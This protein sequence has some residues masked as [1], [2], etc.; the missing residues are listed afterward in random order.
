MAHSRIGSRTRSRRCRHRC[1]QRKKGTLCWAEIPKGCNGQ[2]GS[3]AAGREYEFACVRR[4]PSSNNSYE[5]INSQ[6][7]LPCFTR[8]PVAL[9]PCSDP[10][11]GNSSP[12]N[13]EYCKHYTIFN[14]CPDKN[15]EGFYG[16]T[17][18]CD[19]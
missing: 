12:N 5:C 11:C 16:V 4:I 8:G 14:N 3:S 2:C 17:D 10:I 9:T 6:T 7:V 13:E 18:C 1:L 19:E 15:L